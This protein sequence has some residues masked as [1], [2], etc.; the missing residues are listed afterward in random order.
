MG[1]NVLHNI[2]SDALA[3]GNPAKMRARKQ[4]P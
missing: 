1:A 3:Y 2:D 4:H